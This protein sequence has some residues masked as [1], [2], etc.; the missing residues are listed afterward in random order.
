MK[1]LGSCGP[2]WLAA[3]PLQVASAEDALL[4]CACFRTLRRFADALHS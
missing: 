3:L 2:Q 1:R 4:R